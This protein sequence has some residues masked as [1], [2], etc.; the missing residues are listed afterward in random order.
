MIPVF[1]VFWRKIYDSRKMNNQCIWV[2]CFPTK[3]PLIGALRQK[4]RFKI[5]YLFLSMKIVFQI[6]RIHLRVCAKGSSIRHHKYYFIKARYLFYPVELMHVQQTTSVLRW[7]WTLLIEISYHM[8]D[9][10]FLFISACSERLKT[11]YKL[12]LMSK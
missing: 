8:I 6:H 2:F 7:T 1:P 11:W 12:D 9:Y 3:S 5:L 4:G 10:T